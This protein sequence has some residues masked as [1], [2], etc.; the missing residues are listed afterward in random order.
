MA[1][2]RVPPGSPSSLREANRARI[3]DTIKQLGAMTQVELADAT[4]L[5]P[6]TVSIIVNELAAAGLLTTAQ[7]T[8]S[9]RRATQVAMSRGLGLVAGVHFSSRALRLV[10]CDPLGSVV[11]AQR[12]PL[13][14]DH[15]SDTS[16]DQAAELLHDML[17]DVDAERAELQGVG[18]GICAPYDPTTDMLSVPG[19]LRGWDEVRIAESLSRRLGTPVVADNDANLAML[20]ESRFGIAK[21]MSSAVFVMISHGIGAGIMAHGQILRGHAGLAGEIGHVRVLENGQLCRCGNRGCLEMVVNAT[22]ITAALRN[23]VGS[24]TLRD[25]I[26]MARQGDIGATRVIADAAQHIGFAIAALSNV[27]SP[28]ITVIGGEL[29]AAGGILTVPLEASLERHSL[30]NPLNPPRVHISELGTDAS[31]LGAAAYAIDSVFQATVAS[32]ATA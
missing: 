31:A 10:L 23:T 9:G 20:A 27:V 13:P 5:S 18:V 14:T 30:H 3:L 25:I 22:A 26:A 16:L 17:A 11:A 8:R 21:S 1:I 4:G 29:A 2:P 12:M 28:E 15:R 24:V 19:L 6:A 7:I 32:Q